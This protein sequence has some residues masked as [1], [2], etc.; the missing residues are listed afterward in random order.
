MTDSHQEI[1]TSGNVFVTCNSINADLFFGRKQQ[2]YTFSH[3]ITKRKNTWTAWCDV[4]LFQVMVLIGPSFLEINLMVW[5]ECLKSI[6]ILWWERQRS[7]STVLLIESSLDVR[8][9]SQVTPWVL[10]LQPRACCS[11]QWFAAHHRR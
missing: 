10:A 4:P 3:Q 2:L 11:L 5:I 9:W 6:L 7:I 1:K 8:G